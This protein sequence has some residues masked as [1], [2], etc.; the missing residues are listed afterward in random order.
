MYRAVPIILTVATICLGATAASAAFPETDVFIASAGNGPGAGDSHWYTTL[1]IHNPTSNPADCTISLLIRGQANPSPSEYNV[2]VN[3]G[4]TLRFD[5]AV[6]TLFGL[7]EFG[8][9]RVV[10][11]ERV[12]VNS[13]IYNQPG[14]DRSETQGQFFAAAPAS[15][16]I[17][18]GEHSE[19]LGVDQSTDDAFRYNFGF[20]ETT[21][22][23][24][25]VEV[26]LFQ[27]PGNQLGQRTYTVR[28]HEALQLNLSDLGAGPN[29]TENG[30]IEV[31]VV[32]GSGEVLA[33]GSGI[34]NESGDPST[35]EMRYAH[36]LI[37]SN[38]GGDITS[39]EA[40]DGLTGG[41]ASG[42]V[43]LHVGAGAA[44]DVDANN[45]DIADGGVTQGKLSAT[46]ASS[47]QVL[48]TD[49]S[50]LTWVDSGGFSLPFL[51][52]VDIDD[53]TVFYIS[54]D[55]ISSAAGF[56]E[57]T[58]ASSEV[59]AVAGTTFG[60][61]WGV[62]GTAVP[63]EGGTGVSGSGDLGVRGAGDA[64]FGVFGSS[65]NYPGVAGYGPNTPREDPAGISGTAFELTGLLG[66]SLDG[67][68]V[69]GYSEAPQQGAIWG[70]NTADA[71]VGAYGHVTG[72]NAIGV[73][74]QATGDADR[75]GRF[76]GDV[77]ITGNLSKSGGSFTIDHPLNPDSMYLSHSFVESP[78][79]MNVYN[80][81]VVL[82]NTG[83]AV[84]ELPSWFETLNRDFRYQLTCIG[85]FAPVYIAETISGNTFRIAGGEPGLEVSWQVT[86]IR[87]DPWAQENRI[88]VE[89]DKGGSESGRYLHPEL[90]GQPDQ[91]RIR[92]IPDEGA[93]P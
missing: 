50:N 77:E 68:A 41:G 57:L 79:M 69:Y 31:S 64:D 11:N 67:P 38:G 18:Q 71:A 49:G 32:G 72:F 6:Q 33:F 86:G 63:G 47:G 27:G 92:H 80:G 7:Q 14:S 20:I 16:A 5:E 43:A 44:I 78:D 81:N 52:D 56:F 58:N 60:S 87:N 9:I 26:T 28:G 73:L 70:F 61:G 17:A 62:A 55:G 34:A 59:A 35:F 91:L 46:G 1:W 23:T 24:A 15:F 93:N 19:L 22:N 36:R 90:Y 25:T 75:A 3:A 37:Q 74:G 45:V 65:A 40:G 66:V 8:A 51:A 21:G 82:D 2:T 84:V 54:N 76:E 13:R 4:E 53:D 42:D 39:V 48:G 83:S 30:T 85:G 29:P 10:S 12:V 88:E 89:R